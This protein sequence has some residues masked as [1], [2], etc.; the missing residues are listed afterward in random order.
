[1]QAC[2]P[3]IRQRMMTAFCMHTHY[4]VP[5]TRRFKMA[6]Q[7]SLCSIN[8]KCCQGWFVVAKTQP[9]LMLDDGS[10]NVVQ[11]QDAHYSSSSNIRMAVLQ[12]SI[13]RCCL[14]IDIRG[15]TSCVGDRFEQLIMYRDSHHAGQSARHEQESGS[16]AVWVLTGA[17][18]SERAD[19]GK[20]F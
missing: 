5:A 9:T 19:N 3:Q 17:V 14:Y 8:S 18:I 2:R 11:L 16:C 20:P 12:P 6:G 10:V 1:M 13:H 4:L 7:T 15:M